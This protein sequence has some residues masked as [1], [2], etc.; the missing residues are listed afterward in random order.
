MMK[1]K[2]FGEDDNMSGKVNYP[3]ENTKESPKTFTTKKNNESLNITGNASLDS[4]K[5]IAEVCDEM[6]IMLLQKN[7]Q[8]GDS[9][10][11]P[12]RFFS[13]AD[14]EEQIKVRIDD[15]LNRLVLGN[16]SL[17]SDDDIIKDLIGY[18]T[19]LLVYRRK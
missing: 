18:L 15:K 5:K 10:L 11:N 7:N 3:N 13:H 2:V 1:F 16:D 17:E 14:Q 6:K 9:V 8:Y 4:Q 19:L 12:S